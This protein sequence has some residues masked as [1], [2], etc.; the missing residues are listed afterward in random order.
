[1]EGCEILIQYEYVCESKYHES[2]TLGNIFEIN[3]G[4]QQSGIHFADLQGLKPS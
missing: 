4:S 1:M 2:N 3:A